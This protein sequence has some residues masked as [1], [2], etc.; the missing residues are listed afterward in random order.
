MHVLSEQN[1]RVGGDLP[2]G[3]TLVYT[4]TFA[5]TLVYHCSRHSTMTGI[6]IVNP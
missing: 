4:S 2:S 5:V 1:G 3:Q 6:V